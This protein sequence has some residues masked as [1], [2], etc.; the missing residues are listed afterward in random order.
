MDNGR[1]RNMCHG[2]IILK[3]GKEGEREKYERGWEGYRMKLLRGRYWCQRFFCSEEGG[4]GG[5]G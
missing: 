4:E 2:Y 5:I 3:G 1:G